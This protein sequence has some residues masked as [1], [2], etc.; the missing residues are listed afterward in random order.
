[1]KTSQAIVPLGNFD[2]SCD[3][4]FDELLGRWRGWTAGPVSSVRVIDRGQEFEVRIEAVVEDPGA[5]DVEVA[6][7]MLIVRVPAGA[8]P[9]SEQRFSFGQALDIE[10][11]AARWSGGVLTVTL[12]KQRGRLVKVR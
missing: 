12:P 1:M 7:S 9:R 3:E 11:A 4:L 10:R 5:I 8:C 6:A 2:R